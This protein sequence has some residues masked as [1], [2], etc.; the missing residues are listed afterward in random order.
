MAVEIGEL[1][2]FPG[3]AA[4][5]VGDDEVEPRLAVIGEKISGRDG[6]G[7]FIDSRGLIQ[8]EVVFHR[9]PAV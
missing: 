2:L 8:G 3:H 7:A 6:S 4:F 5:G 9:R 1:S